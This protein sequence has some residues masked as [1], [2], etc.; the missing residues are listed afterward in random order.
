MPT[1]IGRQSPPI[2]SRRKTDLMKDQPA[3]IPLIMGDPECPQYMPRLALGNEAITTRLRW[4]TE[5]PGR[6]RYD[7]VMAA[8]ALQSTK[9]PEFVAAVLVALHTLFPDTDFG[10]AANG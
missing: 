9:A 8:C 7:L 1:W 10:E 6:V 3:V 5:D 4:L 2:S